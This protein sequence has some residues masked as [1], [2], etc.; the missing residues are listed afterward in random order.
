MTAPRVAPTPVEVSQGNV[1]P[2]LEASNL[3]RRFGSALAL[4][5]VSLVLRPGERVGLLGPNGAGKTTLI[6]ILATALRPTTGQL[7]IGGMDA[8]RATSQARARVGLVGHQT[9]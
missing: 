5:G 9:F 4:R 3:T 1:P 8:S 2:L 7:L 6:R